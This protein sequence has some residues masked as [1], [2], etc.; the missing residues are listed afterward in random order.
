VARDLTREVQ[1]PRSL[2]GNEVAAV[3]DEAVDRMADAPKVLQLPPI[4]T[5]IQY[6]RVERAEAQRDWLLARVA[7]MLIDAA[8]MLDPITK[9][10]MAR[11]M[12]FGALAASTWVAI[13]TIKLTPSWEQVATCGL[14]LALSAWLIRAGNRA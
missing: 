4:E 7:I 5:P 14:F 3:V 1:Q 8:K 11:V 12:A 2:N 13:Y 10:V 6:Q 9:I